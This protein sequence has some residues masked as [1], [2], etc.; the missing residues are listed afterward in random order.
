[1]TVAEGSNQSISYAANFFGFVLARLLLSSRMRRFLIFEVVDDI[2]NVVDDLDDAFDAAENDD[3]E[4]A[5]DEFVDDREDTVEGV[6][7]N[8]DDTTKDEPITSVMACF[9]FLDA[10]ADLP[11]FAFVGGLLLL[12]AM[13]GFDAGFVR[14][15]PI[16]VMV[17]VDIFA[18]ALKI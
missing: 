2:D 9:F 6:E 7:S 17:L 4:I 10:A 1:M 5:N 8:G 3:G 14:E 13:V 12:F 15:D 16:E 18:D 11:F